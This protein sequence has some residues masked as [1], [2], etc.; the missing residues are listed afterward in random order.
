MINI[1]TKILETLDKMPLSLQEELLHYAQYL[2]DKYSQAS[3][4]YAHDGDVVNDF[5]ISWHEAMTGQTIPLTE[6]WESLENEE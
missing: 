5:R 1:Q 6:V 3:M 2:Q 4:T